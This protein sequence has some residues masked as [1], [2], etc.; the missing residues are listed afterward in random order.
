MTHYNSRA[1]THS[2]NWNIHTVDPLLR[3]RLERTRTCTAKDFVDHMPSTEAPVPQCLA[4]KHALA[5]PSE[6]EMERELAR[7][8]VSLG[9]AKNALQIFERLEM[10][11][12]AVGCY[13]ARERE[14][15]P[16]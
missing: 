6:W 5:L 12:D 2:K 9:V 7:A 3:S 8:F 15:G 4:Y 10:W 16:V 1:L 13:G 11:E 14:T